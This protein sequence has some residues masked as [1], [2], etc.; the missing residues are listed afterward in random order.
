MKM[1]D[2]LWMAA[3]AVMPG[4][5]GM[6]V[7]GVR[8][9]AAQPSAPTAA[10]E[11]GVERIVVP[12]SDPARPGTLRVHLVTGSIIV[13]G[14]DGRDVTVDSF[15]Q[16]ES[17]RR[18]SGR[19]DPDTSGLR[20]IRSRG[21]AVTVEEENNEMRV[22]AS[23]P[24]E[25]VELII[26]VPRRTSLK[27]DAVNGGRLV[28]ENVDGEIEANNVNGPVTLTDVAGS[29]V[30]HALNDDLVVRMTR[31]SGKPMSFSSLNGDIDVTL[32]P[33]IKANLR[34][35][36]VRGEI[37]TDFDLA[38]LPPQA[39]RTVDDRRKDGGKYKAK[40]EHALVGTINGGGPELT[41]K[42]FNGD[43]RIRK[44]KQDR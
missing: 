44:A 39:Q 40:M 9:P 18:R 2:S 32:P 35:E 42:N 14:Y 17:R 10:P 34:L 13:R 27:L 5:W 1:V 28:V 25:N 37:L 8:Q 38:L 41:F 23:M 6:T 36:T 15:T 11:A 30:A 20:R 26:Q 12:W 33:D 4:V 24:I 31:I 22:S 29:V 43:I 3:L 7:D 21:G 16:D 19:E